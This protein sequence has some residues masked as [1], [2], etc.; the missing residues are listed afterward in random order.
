VSGSTSFIEIVKS[1]LSS[2]KVQ[3]PVFNQIALKIQQEIVNQEP[4]FFKVEQLITNDQAL[5]SEVLKVANSSFYRGFQE[6]TSVKNAIVRLGGK[7]VS[8]IVTLVTHEN[9][10][11]SKDQFLNKIMR[12]LWRHSV[13]CAIGSHWLA[14]RYGM[15]GAKHES[16]F[17]GLLHDVGKLLVLK[18]A[19]NLMTQN[20]LSV[21]VS[22]A[23]LNEAMD[24]LHTDLGYLL[25]KHWN[26]P[27]KYSEIARQHHSVDFDSKDILLIIVRLADKACNKL[28][29][30][31]KVDPTMALTATLEANELRLTEVDLANFE[32]YLED[33][34]IA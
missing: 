12:S 3:L 14:Q 21:Q 7:E 23:L 34:S 26:I 30:G 20:E 4:N 29:I 19:D 8:N 9:H 1:Y 33:T 16:F 5:T 25:M 17:A 15:P 27:D 24:A 31:L 28:G 22:D 32:I 11:H 10:F 2:D 6:I 13:G 18:V